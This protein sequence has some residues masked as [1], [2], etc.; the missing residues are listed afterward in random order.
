[1][2]QFARTYQTALPPDA[3][4]PPSSSSRF[5]CL[6]F[7]LIRPPMASLMP[8]K[9]LF[10]CLTEPSP[11]TTSTLSASGSVSFVGCLSKSS[12]SKKLDLLACEPR[13][14][15]SR[16]LF[17]REVPS[18]RRRESATTAL[19]EEERGVIR[20]AGVSR[21]MLLRAERVGVAGWR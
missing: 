14:R 17:D 5:L 13:R 9:R 21:A 2:I 15:L 16:S 3:P 4:H 18:P 7:P 19:S 12:S 11:P 8:L 10:L 20:G 6:P 1:M